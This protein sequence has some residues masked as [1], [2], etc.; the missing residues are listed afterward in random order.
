M[1]DKEKPG[2]NWPNAIRQC[3]NQ[4]R[5]IIPVPTR[6]RRARPPPLSRYTTVQ[7][8]SHEELQA[9]SQAPLVLVSTPCARHLSSADSTRT[10]VFIQKG[11][12]RDNEGSELRTYDLV[13][14]HVRYGSDIMSFD[15]CRFARNR[16]R[17]WTFWCKPCIASKNVHDVVNLPV[18]IAQSIVQPIGIFLPKLGSGRRMSRMQCY[19][20]DFDERLF[21]SSHTNDAVRKVR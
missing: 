14:I 7:T 10:A 18:F 3:R 19:N 8:P 6:S 2:L 9:D 15:E 13:T 4:I 21:D 5:P 20:C 16:A 1:R 12:V 17:T 11:E